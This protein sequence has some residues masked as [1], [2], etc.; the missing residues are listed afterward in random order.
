MLSNELLAALRTSPEMQ[1]LLGSLK[2]AQSLRELMSPHYTWE[3]PISF[4]TE[5]AVLGSC[6]SWVG[7]ARV[8]G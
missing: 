5:R 3:L 6:L 2:S 7:C 8:L 4:G 1:L